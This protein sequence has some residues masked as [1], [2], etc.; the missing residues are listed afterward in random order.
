MTTQ[1]MLTAVSGFPQTVGAD[2]F[3]ADDTPADVRD[4]SIGGIGI[5][6]AALVQVPSAPVSP[7]GQGF[8]MGCR[9]TGGADERGYSIT[10]NDTQNDLLFSAGDVTT[11]VNIPVSAGKD[12]ALVVGCT[13]AG[14]AEIGM[15]MFVNGLVIGG[16][17]PVTWLPEPTRP[18]EIG[19]SSMDTE[20]WGLLD[21]GV[22]AC[23]TG[24]FVWPGTGPESQE[25]YDVLQQLWAETERAGDII[26]EQGIFSHIWSCR[27]GLTNLVDGGNET[28]TDWR[29]GTVLSRQGTPHAGLSVGARR[30]NWRKVSAAP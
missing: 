12:H 9:E 26:D 5:V 16:N 11:L 24:A 7:S 20:E 22:I 25:F 17:G 19:N 8:F 15:F 1:N 23:A 30:S 2:Y 3:A 4:P 14:I 13:V 27:R 18:F 21:G 10:F 6:V 29:G 28:W